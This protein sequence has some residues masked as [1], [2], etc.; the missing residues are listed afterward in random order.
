MVGLGLVLGLRLGILFPSAGSGSALIWLLPS[1]VGKSMYELRLVVFCIA[2]VY[3]GLLLRL[4]F[5]LG[6]VWL[7]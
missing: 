6:F 3:S 5:I 7:L 4:I 1:V 2:G